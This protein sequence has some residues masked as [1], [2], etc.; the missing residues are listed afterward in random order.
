MLLLVAVGLMSSC[1]RQ[2]RGCVG[3]DKTT[4]QYRVSDKAHAKDRGLFPKNPRKA[5]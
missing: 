2:G 5:F 3:Y 1:Q 4:G